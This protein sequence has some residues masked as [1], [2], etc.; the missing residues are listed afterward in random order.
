[1]PYHYGKKMKSKK[2]KGSKKNKPDSAK[3]DKGKITFSAKTIDKLKKKVADHNAK[4][5]FIKVLA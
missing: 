2:K 4:G 5:K 1:M 3:D